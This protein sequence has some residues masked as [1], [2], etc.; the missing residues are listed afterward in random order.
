MTDKLALALAL[1]LADAQY[2]LYLCMYAAKLLFY[3]DIH[4]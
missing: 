3:T 2:T 4:G 1:A